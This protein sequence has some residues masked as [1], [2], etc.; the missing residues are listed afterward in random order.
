MEKEQT[1]NISTSTIVKLL[2][3]FLVLSFLYLIKEVLLIIFVAL[4]LASAFDPWVDW[5]QKKK[6]PRSLSILIIYVVLFAL[7]TFAFI[8]I[9]PPISKEVIQL[10]ENFP[11]Y[12]EKI[13]NGIQSFQT[14]GNI[15]AQEQLQKGLNSLGENLPGTLS[16]VV[17]TLF[18]VFGGIFSVLLVL[19]LTFY[20]TV[21]EGAMKNF[22]QTI[23]PS[24]AQPY[25]MR[26]YG[27]IQV[28]LGQ[29]LRGQLIL[30]AV[31]FT[32]TF[33]GLTILGVPYALILAFIAGL[34]EIVPM[35]GPWMSAIP[36]VFFGFLQSPLMGISVV[37][38]YI[39]IQEL[40]N[41]LIV[42]KVMSKAVGLN[43]LIVII[44]ILVGMKLGGIVGALLA[45][46]VA[47][48]LSVFLMDLVDKKADQ[49]NQLS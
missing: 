18:D 39:V 10:S 40:E 46:P 37:V 23:T 47:T 9:V 38:L 19:V 8:L 26:L 22:L 32:L 30:S 24:K 7:I 5:F 14:G 27:R 45:V 21:Q 11:L 2:V 43:P 20:F 1:I 4:V 17:N 42:P 16:N 29:W 12:Y 34:F 3:F 49:E 13:A 31:I 25:L 48:A 6:I 28:K 35:I 15:D 41:H 33:I 44:A 36:A